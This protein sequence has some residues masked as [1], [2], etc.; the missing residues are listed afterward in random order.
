MYL[1]TLTFIYLER[2]AEHYLT[3]LTP[4]HI[5]YINKSNSL[6]SRQVTDQLCELLV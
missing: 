4:V 1:F 2:T 5:Y 3:F 6:Q